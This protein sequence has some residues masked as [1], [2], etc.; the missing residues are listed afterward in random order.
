MSSRTTRAT[1]PESIA[2]ATIGPE[3][4]G[5][6]IVGMPFDARG[7][8]ED[9]SGPPSESEQAVRDHDAGRQGRGAR[10]QPLAQ[11]NVVADIQFD[12]R[13]RSV[14]IA[15]HL[16]RGLPDQVRLVT[17]DLARIPA[18][19]TDR[20]AVARDGTGMSGTR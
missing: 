4:A 7:F 10:A 15:S 16:Q 17:R 8:V 12:R 6:D 18:G 9:S 2:L 5:A 1:P 3:H 20:Q 19:H 13:Q 14:D 11:R